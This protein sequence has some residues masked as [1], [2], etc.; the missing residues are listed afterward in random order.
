MADHNSDFSRTADGVLDSIEE[1]NGI[2]RGSGAGAIPGV[3][4]ASAAATA[5]VIVGRQLLGVAD[6]L[7]PLL[8]GNKRS[9]VERQR[10]ALRASITAAAEAEAKAL[11]G[12]GQ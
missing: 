3:A 2:I 6:L 4:T 10:D 7:I 11:E 9:E 1:I 8:S 12:G 5:A